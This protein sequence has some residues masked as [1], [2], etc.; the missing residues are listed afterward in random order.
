MYPRV[1][2]AADLR[3]LISALKRALKPNHLVGPD[4]QP[5]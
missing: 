2:Q 3:T 4:S 5:V 1:S